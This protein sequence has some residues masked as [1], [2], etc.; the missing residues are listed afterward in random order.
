ML[1]LKNSMEDFRVRCSSLGAIMTDARSKTDPLGATC[2]KELINL[3]VNY[4]YGRKKDI[5]TK[6]MEKGLRV[7]EDAIDLY[8]K[9]TKT[10]FSKNELRLKDDHISGIPDLYTGKTIH[11]A[12]MIIDVKSSWDIFTFFEAKTSD[13][14]KA[15]Y[16]QL[17]GY[18][19]LTGASHA[20]LAYCLINT[21]DELIADEK[22]K[23]AWKMGVID[24]LAS[25]DY[26]EACKEIDR[27]SI[28]DDLDLNERIFMLDLDRDQ[29][30]INAIYAKV[31]EC[32]SW[33]AST[34][35]PSESMTETL[36]KSIELQK[37]LA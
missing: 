16:W 4:R 27:L 22:R 28:Y 5:T 30:A 7:E 12:T 25:P 15:Y 21:P 18:M 10:F 24:D 29:T 31:S 23:L 9:I 35:Y 3:Y 33:L 37:E 32:R 11:A 34:F 20:R 26:I 19:A 36:Q 17:Q 8:S 2:R 14:N 6:Y 1:N 13:I